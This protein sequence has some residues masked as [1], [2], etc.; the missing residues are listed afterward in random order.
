MDQSGEQ[1]GT[2]RDEEEV[3]PNDP[4]ESAS[5]SESAELVRQVSKVIVERPDGHK[6]SPMIRHRIHKI[7][8]AK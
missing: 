4:G 6:P 8:R 7:G 5:G 3:G 1:T 2:Q